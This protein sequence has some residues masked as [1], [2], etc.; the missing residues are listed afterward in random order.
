M[1]SVEFPSESRLFSHTDA[2]CRGGRIELRA[3]RRGREA[4]EARER[5]GRGGFARRREQ[6]GP[7]RAQ[8]FF[9][10]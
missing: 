10:V 7:R 2:G 9:P 3:G 8:L 1:I 5:A 6:A 4:P